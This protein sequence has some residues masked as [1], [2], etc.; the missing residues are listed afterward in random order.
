[1]LLARVLLHEAELVILDEPEAA[2]DERGRS[3]LRAL[4]ARLA[5]ERKVLIIAHDASV[6]PPSFDRLECQ[7]ARAS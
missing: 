4:L 1:M 7:R 6:V 2:L 3:T 5:E